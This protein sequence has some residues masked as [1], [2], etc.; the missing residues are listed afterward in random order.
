[1]TN[2][3]TLA[4]ITVTALLAA[5]AFAQD[6][7]AQDPGIQNATEEQAT[8]LAPDNLTAD[9]TVADLDQNGSLNTD[10]F[11]TFAVMRGDGGDEGYKDVVLAGNFDATFNKHDVDQSGSIEMSE[12]GTHDAPITDSNFEELELIVPETPRLLVP[13]SKE[14]A[15]QDLN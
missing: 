4:V 9:Y 13:K 10:E 14:N 5:P 15:K 1:M 3:K 8:E 12:L 7:G 11:V 2:I 6:A